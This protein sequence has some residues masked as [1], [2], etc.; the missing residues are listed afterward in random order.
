M[1]KTAQVKTLRSMLSDM[2]NYNDTIVR[3]EDDEDHTRLG[4]LVRSASYGDYDNSSLMEVS[5]YRY[6][7]EKYPNDVTTRSG[8]YG[9]NELIILG[10]ALL[11]QNSQIKSDYD[12]L[13][14]Y[15]L[16]SE[17]LHSTI[18]WDSYSEW[19]N[20]EE[21]DCCKKFLN[22]CENILTE[23]QH[24]H[25][26]E[27]LDILEWG[28][29]SR[30]LREY[31]EKH[32]ISGEY[33]RDESPHG[34]Y[35]DFDPSEWDD[36]LLIECI[37]SLNCGLISLEQAVEAYNQEEK[38]DTD[39]VVYTGD[40]ELYSVSAGLPGC[41]PNYSSLHITLGDAIEDAVNYINP[42][43]NFDSQYVRDLISDKRYYNLDDDIYLGIEKLNYLPF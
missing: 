28:I 14:E 11:K 8:Y 33:Y 37:V 42:N 7:T 23:K 43:C 36:S 4:I 41:L 2:L 32:N 12:S 10:S 40:F 35:V 9:S 27:Q 13:Q 18:C 20:D 17:E 5:N 26:S 38:V 25:L 1:L 30:V 34:V 39:L 21:Y 29:A 19:W 22:D 3:L 6:L 24:D 31:H 15:P 16:L